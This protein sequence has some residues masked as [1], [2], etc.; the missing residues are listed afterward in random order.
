MNPVP[1]TAEG[2]PRQTTASENP[3]C[4]RI[5]GI[6]ATWPNMSGR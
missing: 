5:W 2:T 3:A 4:R 6:W 1:V